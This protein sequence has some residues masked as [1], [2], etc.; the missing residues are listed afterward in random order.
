VLES[1][2]TR[3]GQVTIPKEIRERLGAKEGERVI[4]VPR[5]EEIVLKVIHGTILDLKGSVK[6]R[7]RPENFDEVRKSVRRAVAKRNAQN[8]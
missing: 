7:K 3:K 4:F 5:G 1:T 2:L 8:G 6:A